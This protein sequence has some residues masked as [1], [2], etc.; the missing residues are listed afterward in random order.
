MPKHKHIIQ[1]GLVLNYDCGNVR[2]FVSGATS[3]FD[4]AGSGYTGTITG[5]VYQSA[6][7]G[8][9]YFDGV[10][11]VIDAGNIS[12]LNLISGGT[13]SIWFIYITPWAGTSSYPNII[14]KGGSAGSDTE[15]WAIFAFDPAAWNV[16][17]VGSAIRNNTFSP[18]NN[19][20]VIS[21]PT[22]ANVFINVTQTFD[23]TAHKLYYNG[24]LKANKSTPLLPPA[25]SASFKI[26]SGPTKYYLNG[27]ISQAMV[28]NRAL[29]AA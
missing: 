26:M 13:I 2:S 14:S 11:D 17:N 4:L 12:A 20:R 9:L 15:G 1:S 5:A 29:T 3:I 25:S 18:V 16:N 22:A 8:C 21:P 6:N 27:K 24:V 23:G 7:G 19:I 10:N 28:Y